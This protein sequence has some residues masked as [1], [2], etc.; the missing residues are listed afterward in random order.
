MKINGRLNLTPHALVTSLI[1]DLLED[2]GDHLYI[3]LWGVR[4]QLD[5][6]GWD[7]DMLGGIY[8]VQPSDIFKVKYWKILYTNN[9][10]L[11]EWIIEIEGILEYNY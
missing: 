6:Q 8:H 11:T 4:Y 2:D 9:N 3:T 5:Q 7:S 10:P 1:N